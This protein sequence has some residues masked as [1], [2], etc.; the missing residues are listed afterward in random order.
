MRMKLRTKSD[1][2][3]F[4]G[5]AQEFNEYWKKKRRASA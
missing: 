2:V 5:D 4:F 3:E 1:W